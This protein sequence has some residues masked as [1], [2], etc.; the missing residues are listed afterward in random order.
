MMLEDLTAIGRAIS[1]HHIRYR[2]IVDVRSNDYRISLRMKFGPEA[3]GS[4]T[5]FQIRVA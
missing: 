5:A 3:S 2:K 4:P 1:H